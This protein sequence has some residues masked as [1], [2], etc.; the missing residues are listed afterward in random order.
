MA[1]AVFAASV[2]G[3]TIASAANKPVLTHP[4]GTSLPTGTGFLGRQVGAT[5][6]YSTSGVKEMECSS[7]SMTGT[8]LKNSGGTVEGE[9]SSASFGGT[10]AQVEGEPEPECTSFG[11]FGLNLSVTSNASS[12]EPWC[13]KSNT[14]MVE[15]TFM[16][17]GGK[18]GVAATKIRFVELWTGFGECVYQAT[19]ASIKG[20]FTT[21]G[22]GDAVVTFT[23]SNINTGL[24]KVSGA[25]ACPS[26]YEFELAFTLETDNGAAREP[27]YISK[28]S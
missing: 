19:Q 3:A 9:I 21:D 15:D 27:I 28:L 13:I 16:L 23:R 5:G 1:V 8:L 2:D 18:C 6:F 26:S 12:A 11:F 10:G 24:S 22:T 20:T 4:T 25:F 14:L 17:S 7:G